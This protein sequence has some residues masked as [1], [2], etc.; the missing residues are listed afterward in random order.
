MPL[1]FYQKIWNKIRHAELIFHRPADSVRLLAVTKGRELVVIKELILAGQK[2]FGENYLSEA[3]NKIQA[4]QDYGLEW[5]FIGNLQANKTRAVAENFAWVHSVNRFKIAKRLSEQR[6]ENLP[7]LNICLEVNISEEHTKSG[8]AAAQVLELAS[9]IQELPRVR[10]R[11]LMAIPEQAQQFEEQQA[12]YKKVF[13]LQQQLIDQ[14]FE[15]D[16][17]S[18]GMSQDFEAAIAAGS[19]LVRIGAALFQESCS[20]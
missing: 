19:N 3:L 12:I 13:N 7:P 10:L 14:G 6:P 1:I 15:L 4:L 2:A 16:T 20:R 17:L 18:M 9:Q 8:V 11:G 5:H